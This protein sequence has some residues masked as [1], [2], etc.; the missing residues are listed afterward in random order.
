MGKINTEVNELHMDGKIESELGDYRSFYKNVYLSI[1]DEEELEVK[2]I[3]AR[4][5]I[6][7][8]ELA[9]KSSEEKC[10]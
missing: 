5:T 3:Q 10:G 4:N 1:L 6:R 8:I 2:P 9:Q 7:I